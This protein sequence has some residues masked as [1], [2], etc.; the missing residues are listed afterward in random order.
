M[1]QRLVV[2]VEDVVPRTLPLLDAVLEED[3]VIAHL[4]DG[5]H[6]VGVDHGADVILLRDVLYQSV[7]D[8]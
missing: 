6:V 4:H 3:N 2:G 1:V 8:E 7:D 5:V